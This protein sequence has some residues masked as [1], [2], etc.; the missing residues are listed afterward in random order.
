[1]IALFEKQVRWIAFIRREGEF[2]GLN[3]TCKPNWRGHADVIACVAQAFAEGDIRY[4]VAAC[5]AGEEGDC[6][7][8][9]KNLVLSGAV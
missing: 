9:V 2:A 4:D 1:M 5:A 3:E 6:F 7:G 8:H